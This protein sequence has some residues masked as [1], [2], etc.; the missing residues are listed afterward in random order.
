[1]RKINPKTT[2]NFYLILCSMT[3]LTVTS[4]VFTNNQSEESII[5]SVNNSDKNYKNIEAELLAKFT[6]QNINLIAI[7]K[8]VKE[9]EVPFR[10]KCLATTVIEEQIAI[11]DIINKI[12]SEKLIIVPNANTQKEVKEI[13][14]TANENIMNNYLIIT[15][16]ILKKQIK[17]LK[18]LSETTS[19]V[20]FKI[21][22]LQT[23]VKLN[24]TLYKV[25]ETNNTLSA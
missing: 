8:D 7:S 19:D 10:I 13:K 6:Q 9:K 23:I 3:F 21:L 14:E 16:S 12:T 22:A 11:N 18:L 17:N 1:M 25:E 5:S 4:C 2:L 24:S 20:D 15:T